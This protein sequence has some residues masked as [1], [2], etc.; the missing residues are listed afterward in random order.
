VQHKVSKVAPEDHRILTED[1]TLGKASNDARSD[2]NND[3]EAAKLLAPRQDKVSKDTIG[4][5]IQ[6]SYSQGYD[7][8]LSCDRLDH[9]R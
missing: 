2:E 1:K 8:T 6:R 9:L 3:E 7:P 4:R 5:R